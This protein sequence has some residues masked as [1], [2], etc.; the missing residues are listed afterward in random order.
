MSDV[1]TN[2]EGM[3]GL[4]A[5][6]TMRVTNSNHQ[7]FV[8]ASETFEKGFKEQNEATLMPFSRVTQSPTSDQE[9]FLLDTLDVLQSM[10]VQRHQSSGQAD[11]LVV[12][13]IPSHIQFKHLLKGQ[14]PQFLCWSPLRNSSLNSPSNQQALVMV[15]LS[16]ITWCIGLAPKDPSTWCTS[17]GCEP[18]C[19]SC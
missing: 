17:L 15:L 10:E 5:N 19:H 18:K 12:N 9:P 4:G 11:N 8:R 3:L 14:N 2:L 13:I 7:K 6:D 1:P 16:T